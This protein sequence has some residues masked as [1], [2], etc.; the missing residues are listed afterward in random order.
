M[1]LLDGGSSYCTFLTIVLLL[2]I[3][4]TRLD[5]FV[6]FGTTSF[7]SD[8]LVKFS[9]NASRSLM[10]ARFYGMSVTFEVDDFL[11]G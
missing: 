6:T 4:Y 7:E 10:L 2:F 11:F 9:K 5:G 1:S 8:F 3:F